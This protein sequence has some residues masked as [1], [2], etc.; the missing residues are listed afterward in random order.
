MKTQLLTFNKLLLKSIL[1]ITLIISIGCSKDESIADPEKEIE[2]ESETQS[3]NNY[4][5]A[6]S[7]NADEILGVEDTGGEAIK[8]TAGASEEED[9]DIYGDNVTTK[10]T[11]TD[12]N[13]KTNFESIA[14]LKPLEGV[15]YPGALVVGDGNMTRGIPDPLAID[16]GP[17][18]IRI[19]LPGIGEAGNQLIEAPS[20]TN[21]DAGIDKALE[22]WNA[23]AYQDG[24]VNP[25]SQYSEAKTSHSSKQASIELGLNASWASN[26]MA[27]QFNYETTSTKRVAMMSFKQVFYTVT[28]DF[29]DNPSDVFGESV[30]L[31]KIERTINSEVPP[32]FVHSVSYGRI[33]M[34]RMESNYEMSETE[35]KG[36]F[37]YAAG[38]RDASGDTEITYQEILENSS[39]TTVVLGGNAK[40]GAEAVSAKNFGDLEKIIK[41]ENAVYSRDNPGV[42]ISYTVRYLKDNKLAKMGTSTDYQVVNCVT[43]G[44]VHNEIRFT[45][46]LSDNFR[47]GI[48]YKTNL[49][50]ENNVIYDNI[51]WKNNT[52]DG[53]VTSI[54]PPDGAY[55]I[56]YHVERDRF[57]S[58]SG[59]ESKLTRNMGSWVHTSGKHYESCWE[60]YR[61]WGSAEVRLCE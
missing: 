17:M 7:Y 14:I 35:F 37:E 42:P 12:Y 56:I 33:I 38:K 57:G 21:V 59:Y 13:L 44:T 32:A 16:R 19:D 18:T 60:S 15:V 3:I 61:K 40:V 25:A 36:S 52:T 39:I 20:F 29:P 26:E 1:L 45:N 43:T 28:M 54:Y 8:K 6:L 51:V 30:S 11:T 9:V 27:A 58:N 48:E 2:K 5:K 4:I 46:R 47:I 41:G 50:G 22:W 24:Y 34:F 10:C 49:P 23:N 55:D 53:A 31:S